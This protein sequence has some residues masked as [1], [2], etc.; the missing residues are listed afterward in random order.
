[1]K[2]PR[3]FFACIFAVLALSFVVTV[4][5]LPAAADDAIKRPTDT[6]PNFILIFI[7]DMGYGDLGC[8][9]SKINRTPSIDRLA[10]EGVKM[11]SFYSACSV[12]TPSR[13]ALM[14]GC[15]PQRV[16]MHVDSGGLCVL[17][18]AGKKGLN[19]KEIT[20]A[21]I[22]KDRGYETMCIGKWHLGDQPPFL[23]TRQ[24]F[25][26]YYGIPYSNDMNRNFAPL[27]LMRDETTFEAPVHQDDITKRYTEEAI[28]FITKSKDKPFFLYLPH[29]MVHAPL[30]ASEAFR[31]RTKHGIF[32]DAVEEL[33]WSTGEIM[34]TLDKLGIDERTMIIFTSDNGG[35]HLA[36]ND[37]LRGR[38]GQTWEGGMREPCLIRWPGQ[39]PAG[40]VCDEVSGTID[41]LPTFAH[42]TGGKV[43]TDRVID[44]KNIWPLL[45]GTPGA[46]SPHEA[47]Y[48]YQK[49]QL[50]AVRA[51]QWK[52]FPAMETKIKNWGK[53]D[54]NQPLQL[55]DL[56]ADIAESKNL[57]AEHPEVVAR[58]T[59]L[60]DKMRA[61]LGDWKQPGKA[62]R[63]AA[64][65]E[66]PSPRLLPSKE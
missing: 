15:Y 23:P 9:G 65:V 20:I 22:L 24:G 39:I 54:L 35:M 14:T 18:P 48:Y 37:P 8:Y 12:C 13:A 11:T 42:L 63:P 55:Y 44:G 58:L 45:A 52:L 25:D 19:P 47:Y 50:Q 46:V 64:M 40:R 30:K 4:D 33:D 21:E 34:K 43:P 2:S 41:I 10:S 5:C 16:D 49:D 29:T 6:P 28:K 26:S 1:M 57:A 59:A 3:T 56:D 53:P 66:D 62:M 61:E 27:P 60:M 32:S 31:G 38:K 36:C 17:F 7:D 51:G